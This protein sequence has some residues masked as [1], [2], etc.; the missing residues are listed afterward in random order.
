M[1]QSNLVVEVPIEEKKQF[2]E[3]SNNN[4]TIF[5]MI[6]KSP[7]EDDD[8]FGFNSFKT[9]IDQLIDITPSQ[10]K[11]KEKITALLKLINI[12]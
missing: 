12:K 10:E 6:K 11:I 1:N 7:D 9:V 8:E 5:R 3:L 4:S 2:M